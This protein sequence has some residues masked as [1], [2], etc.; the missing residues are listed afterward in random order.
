M[1]RSNLFFTC[2]LV[3]SI[4]FLL[5]YL[6]GYF[7]NGIVLFGNDYQVYKSLYLQRLSNVFH[8][9][10]LLPFFYKILSFTALPY[11]LIFFFQALANFTL[12][13]IFPKRF[14]KV[15]LL[16]L[17]TYCILFAPLV[18]LL[19][20]R[21]SFAFTLVVLAYLNYLYSK[22]RIRTFLSIL[23]VCLAGLFHNTAFLY[24]LPFCFIQIYLGSLR[25]SNYQLVGFTHS[26]PRISRFIIVITTSC[27][28]L[29]LYFGLDLINTFLPLIESTRFSS[30][31]YSWDGY[32]GITNFASLIPYGIALFFRKITGSR[33]DILYFASIQMFSIALLTVQLHLVSLQFVVAAQSLYLLMLYYDRNKSS[34]FQTLPLVFSLLF[35]PLLQLYLLDA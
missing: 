3:F 17:T 27:A 7:E 5:S 25:K 10:P 6:S 30:Y 20:I 1:T 21:S 32:S 34:I 4:C 9:E 23:L 14:D 8:S 15:N 29:Q 35:T 2:I 16:L 12:K 31:V 19:R 33:K 13:F 22:S 24:L 11:G 18:D 28:V 26:S